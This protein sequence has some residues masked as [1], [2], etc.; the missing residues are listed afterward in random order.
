MTT[1]TIPI[2]ALLGFS[3]AR[4]YRFIAAHYGVR[5]DDLR[6]RRSNEPRIV[7]QAR[8]G[9]MWWLATECN[10]NHASVARLLGMTRQAVD[11][12]VD[13]HAKRIETFRIAHKIEDDVA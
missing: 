5:V 11:Q 2:G 10:L 13:L 12:G 8:H 6:A 4:A 7:T 3:L 9:L 1:E